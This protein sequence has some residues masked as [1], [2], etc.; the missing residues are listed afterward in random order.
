MYM[1]TVA[2]EL[3]EKAIL[4]GLQLSSGGS[5]NSGPGGTRGSVA[6]SG[7]GAGSGWDVEDSLNELRLLAESAGAIVLASE[8]QRRE[9]P[10][11]AFFVGEGK[12]Q[13]IAQL[14]EELQANLVIFDDQLSPSQLRHL[15]E[16]IPVKIIDRTALILDIFAQRAMSREGKIQ[17]ELAQLKY[18][19]P[20]LAGQ[21]TA[22]SRMG[23]GGG[24]GTRRGPGET[25]LEMDRR[26]IRERISELEKEIDSVQA[27]R[28]IQRAP[29]KKNAAPLAA[30]VG[31]TNSG[32]STLFNV[33]TEAG[34]L[35][36]DRLFATLD[37]IVRKFMLP[38]GREI[39]L[40]DTVGFIQKLPHELVAAF[41]GTL[42]EA[43]YADILIHVA[44][45]SHPQLIEQ[46]ATVNE[47]LSELG[48]G[49]KPT[50]MV[51]NK[52]DRLSSGLILERLK[53]DFP[54][55]VAIS[56]LTGEGLEDF[57]RVL[58]ERGLPQRVSVELLIPYKD[59][60]IIAEIRA[61]SSQVEQEE[62]LAE[63][64][65][66]KALMELPD[67]GRVRRYVTPARD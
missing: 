31:Y 53:R 66:V 15:E 45:V 60:G 38:D 33:L 9:H 51:F 52:I 25:K 49:D 3:V 22:L 43:R 19:L 6:G 34:V 58:N 30:L 8:I 62:Y 26:R 13:E 5:G 37:P 23:G 7:S 36:E 50:I 29:R 35:A 61:G 1:H 47:V 32:K 40:A 18:A 16:V 56:A 55:C 4:V 48:I 46:C 65:R 2:D 27:N 28:Q 39:L 41:R 21:G 63:G 64:I 17:V 11:P 67:L 12:A 10:D 20:R 24:I 42:E 54:G 59:A 14:C 57:K 44:D